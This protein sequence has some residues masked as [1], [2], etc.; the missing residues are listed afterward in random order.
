MSISKSAPGSSA[1]E[2]FGAAFIVGYFDSIDEMNEIYDRHAGHR[3]LRVA[4][5]SWELVK[6]P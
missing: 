6:R 4:A 2:A 3:G 5:D 1:G